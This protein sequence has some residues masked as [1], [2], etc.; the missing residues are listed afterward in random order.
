MG[1]LCLP[2]NLE[3]NN[4]YEALPAPWTDAVAYF[5]A[6][7]IYEELQNLNAANYYQQQFDKYL[8]GYSQ[9]ARIGRAT[10][11]YGRY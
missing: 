8:L 11:P 4:D 2:S 10:N 7:L 6:K 5:A 3:T 9:A 1:L